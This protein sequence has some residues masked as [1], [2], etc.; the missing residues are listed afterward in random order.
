MTLF[1]VLSPELVRRPGLTAG[2]GFQVRVVPTTWE[3]MSAG[4]F[5]DRPVWMWESDP[6][7]L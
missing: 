7:P 6:D 3:A 2:S 4:E 5:L 1:P